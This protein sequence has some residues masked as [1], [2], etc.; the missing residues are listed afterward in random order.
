MAAALSLSVRGYNC[1]LIHSGCQSRRRHTLTLFY[2]TVCLL[3]LQTRR[4]RRS[5]PSSERFGQSAVQSRDDGETEKLR[6]F[7]L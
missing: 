5:R 3:S 4:R 2:P 6:R 7:G 1:S